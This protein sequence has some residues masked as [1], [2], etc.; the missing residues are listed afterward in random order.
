VKDIR[1]LTFLLALAFTLA[2]VPAV[3]AQ[4]PMHAS[5]PLRCEMSWDVNWTIGPYGGWEGTV[6]GDITGDLTATLVDP[7]RWTPHMKTEHWI[8]TWVI[9]TADGNIY[10]KE[11]GVAA[12]NMWGL[13]KG[14]ITDATG[15]WEDLIGCIFHWSGACEMTDPEPPPAIHC[16]LTMFILPS[17]GK[18]W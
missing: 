13:A 8:E 17:T 1:R 16:E 3:S 2:L 6:S 15:E 7:P 12:P 11:E 4:P 14:R 9:V 5:A 10:G 18:P